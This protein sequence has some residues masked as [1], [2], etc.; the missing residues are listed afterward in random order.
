MSVTLICCSYAI[1]KICCQNGLCSAIVG[2][3]CITKHNTAHIIC[4]LVNGKCCFL[5]GNCIVVSSITCKLCNYCV[6]A[7]IGLTVIFI[8]YCNTGR[9][10][11]CQNGLC[12]AVVNNCCIAEHN[13]AH[14]ICSLVNSKCCFHIGNI[15]IVSITCEACYCIICTCICTLVCCIRYCYTVRK[16]TCNYNCMFA[17]VICYGYVIILD[18]AHIVGCFVNCERCFH[19]GNIVVVSIACEAC[20]CIICTCICTLVC[21]IRYCYTVRKCTCNYNCMFA[22]VICYGYVIILDAAHIVGCFVN[23]ERCFHIR[24]CVVVCITC[25]LSNYC[26]S[27]CISFIVIFVCYCNTCRKICCFK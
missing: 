18:A 20:Y 12:S 26:V 16:C 27:A 19:I 14:I 23:C 11:C 7:C 13:T 3:C 2:Y 25:K 24:N 17:T 4:S 10:I 8:C 22:T 5:V 9:K 21:C 15:V 6:Y 1:R